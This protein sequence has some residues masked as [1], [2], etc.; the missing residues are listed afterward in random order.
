M[1]CYDP[2]GAARKTLSGVCHPG[3]R[4]HIKSEGVP[5]ELPPMPWTMKIRLRDICDW[6][7]E[8]VREFEM[9]EVKW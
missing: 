6:V 1:P 4:V 9:Q 8:H 2:K 3:S 7:N 5:Y